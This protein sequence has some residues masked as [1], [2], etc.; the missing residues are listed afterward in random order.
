[1]LGAAIQCSWAAQKKSEKARGFHRASYRSI[2]K[3]VVLTLPRKQRSHR[4]V[5]AA[6][7]EKV[8]EG[9]TLERN[10]ALLL[11]LQHQQKELTTATVTSRVKK[12]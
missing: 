8:G 4:G 1:M 11:S 6:S 2:I 5:S 3:G 9:L 12:A 7:Q 10:D